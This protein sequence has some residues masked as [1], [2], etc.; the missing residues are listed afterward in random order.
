[1]EIEAYK[2]QVIALQEALRNSLEGEARAM[3]VIA[4]MEQELQLA[5]ARLYQFMADK[6]I[7][8]VILQ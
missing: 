8:P 4:D 3:V 1:M 6:T 2:A 5:K 7:D